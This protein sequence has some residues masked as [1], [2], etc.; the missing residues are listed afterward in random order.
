[1]EDGRH[2]LSDL[3]ILTRATKLGRTVFTPDA[4]F[5]GNTAVWLQEIR[6]FE[7]VIF[8]HQRAV[9][10]R[11]A[12]TDLETIASVLTQDELKNQL[13]RLPLR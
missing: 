3:E 1:M 12:V 9:S 7:G 6:P 5:I 13:I 8:G 4:D 11:K 2:E 10:I